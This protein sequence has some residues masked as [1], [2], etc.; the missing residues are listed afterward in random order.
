VNLHQSTNDVY[1]TALKVAAII[2][3]RALAEAAAELQGRCQDREQAFADIVKMGRTELQDAVPMTLGAEFGAFAEAFGRDRWRAFKC[4]ERLRVVNLGGTAVG[5]GMTAPRR[6]IHLVIETLREVTGIGLSRGEHTVDATANADAYVEV[7]G[8][9]DACGANLIKVSRDLRLLHYFG[10]I[11]L[12]PLQA[13][14]SIMPGKVN[15]V[16]LEGVVSAALRARANGTAV[17]E[18]ASLG[19]LQINEWHPVIADA[20]LEALDLLCAGCR[21]LA[22]AVDTLEADAERCRQLMEASPT[23]LTAFIPQIGYERAE[24]LREAFAADGEKDF[25]A[26]LEEELGKEMVERVLAPASLTQ[27]GYR[28]D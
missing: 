5:T 17:R 10:E 28:D 16:A 6:Y 2:R 13:G 7:M 21:T 12:V 3:L 18:A 26:F 8:M 19:T 24:S 22:M 4:E 27:L 20:L 9:L 15:P 11:R 25:R 23:L 14:S 1:P